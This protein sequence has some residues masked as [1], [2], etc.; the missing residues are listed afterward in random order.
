MATDDGID[1]QDASTVENG[2]PSQNI[3][4]G[5]WVRH[6]VEYR[7]AFTNN[8]I[9]GADVKSFDEEHE[10]AAPPALN[11]PIFE[12]LQIFDIRTFGDKNEEEG[13]KKLTAAAANTIPT[14]FLRIYSIAI[15]NALRSVVRY[16]PEQDLSG[17]SL[18]VRHP[19][20]ILVHH[21]KELSAFRDR[22][23]TTAL[24]ELCEREKHA[25]THLGML[26]QYLD[27]SVMPDVRV[28]QER[29]RR[30]YGTWEN[31]WLALRP[32][33]TILASRLE[34]NEFHPQVVHSLSKGIFSNPPSMWHLQYWYVE[35]DG[36]YLGRRLESST[37]LKWD[38]EGELQFKIIDTEDGIT[39]EEARKFVECGKIY[40]SLLRK[41]CRYY[42]GKTR[43]FPFNEASR[44]RC[45]LLVQTLTQP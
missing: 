10:S 28:E 30:G 36:Q 22:H 5:P 41:Q 37:F 34:D 16:Y 33:T 43:N 14:Y 13:D 3:E 8:L 12:L 17:D 15:I 40:W 39:N 23:A 31:L 4:T 2:S 35:Y 19:Y 32:G 26:L 38:G 42:K 25:S 27:T 18:T 11:E 29:N 9:Y 44:I 24:G 1:G 21:Y 45:H 6:R 7:S 20:P